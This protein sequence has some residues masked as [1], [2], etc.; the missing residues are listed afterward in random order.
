MLGSLGLPARRTAALATA[1]AIA[2][3]ALV[4]GVAGAQTSPFTAYGM[5]LEA[6][7]EVAAYVDGRRCGDTTADADGN[8]LRSISATDPCLPGEGDEITFTLD[9]LATTAKVEW[10]AGGAPVDVASGITLEVADESGGP[11]TGFPGLTSVGAFLSGFVPGVNIAVWGGGSVE[12]LVEAAR[13]DRATSVWAVLDGEL[14]GLIPGA[15]AFL[16]AAFHAMFPEG[17]VRANQPL[18]VVIED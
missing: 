2:L 13:A 7:A 14:V 5:G 16:N 8:W 1:G 11:P 6:G 15:P 9:G 17:Q 4:P 18:I 10:T 3:A 12:E